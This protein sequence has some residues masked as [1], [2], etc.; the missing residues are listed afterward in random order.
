MSEDAFGYRIPSNPFR[1]AIRR[2]L[3]A[4]QHINYY[5]RKVSD[6]IRLLYVDGSQSLLRLL[7]LLQPCTDGFDG[8]HGDGS[9]PQESGNMCM[10]MMSKN[11][12]I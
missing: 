4:R 5:C 8:G 3:L 1:P 9:Q 2:A 10:L 12:P 6:I 7:Q 11:V